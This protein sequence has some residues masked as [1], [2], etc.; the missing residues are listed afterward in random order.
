[1]GDASSSQSNVLVFG[2]TRSGGQWHVVISSQWHTRVVRG[3][4]VVIRRTVEMPCYSV[5]KA[6]NPET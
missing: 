1:M 5:P 3:E 4:R 6:V 2:V